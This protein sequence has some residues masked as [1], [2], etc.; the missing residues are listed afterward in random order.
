MNSSAFSAD[1]LPLCF[2]SVQYRHGVAQLQ[3]LSSVFDYRLFSP[4]SAL[5]W[6]FQHI[7]SDCLCLPVDVDEIK[8]QQIGHECCCNAFTMQAAVA[9]TC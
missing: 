4:F 9:S 8:K 1:L 5:Y 3:V 7:D 2:R 6:E